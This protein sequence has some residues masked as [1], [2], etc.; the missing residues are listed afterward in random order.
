M[1]MTWGVVSLC[2]S[3]F[4]VSGAHMLGGLFHMW[5]WLVLLACLVVQGIRLFRTRLR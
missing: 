5:D 1:A 2:D 3:E 4:C